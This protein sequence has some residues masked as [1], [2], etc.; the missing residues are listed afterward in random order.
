[1]RATGTRPSSRSEPRPV[2]RDWISPASSRAIEKLHEYR[3]FFA[4]RGLYSSHSRCSFSTRRSDRTPAGVPLDSVRRRAVTRPGPAVNGEERTRRPYPGR[5]RPDGARSAQPPRHWLAR[6]PLR[7]RAAPRRPP[8]PRGSRAGRGGRHA[9]DRE[10][11]AS[12]TA[13][14]PVSL[15][16]GG[17]WPPTWSRPERSRGASCRSIEFMKSIAPAEASVRSAGR[18]R[19]RRRS[20][21]PLSSPHPV[22]AGCRARKSSGGARAFTVLASCLARRL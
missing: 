3:A 2:K 10:S 14:A 20:S 19:R 13:G 18:R 5:T 1:M 21:S 22:P 6:S 17:R 9:R 7:R 12:A 4:A 16:R 11:P 15:P 8:D